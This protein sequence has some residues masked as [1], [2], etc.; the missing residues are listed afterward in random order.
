MDEFCCDAFKKADMH[1]T[2]NEGYGPLFEFDEGEWRV[3]SK[4]PAPIF[5][6]W[7]GK[8]LAERTT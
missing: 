8:R 1:N 7:C 4:L 2:D 6:P 5:C 3:G